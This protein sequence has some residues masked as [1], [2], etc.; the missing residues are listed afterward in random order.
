MFW[1]V[2]LGVLYKGTDNQ[3]FQILHAL[4]SLAKKKKKIPKKIKFSCNP[5]R[6]KITEGPNEWQ[7]L[8]TLLPPLVIT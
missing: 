5:T 1:G 8:G 3:P 6:K 7:L 2:L 4:L